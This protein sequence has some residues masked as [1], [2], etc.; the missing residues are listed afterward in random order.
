MGG[1]NQVIHKVL[2]VTID[3]LDRGTLV[4]IA[5]ISRAFIFEIHDKVDNAYF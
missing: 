2:I 4:G 3:D 5:A 1:V